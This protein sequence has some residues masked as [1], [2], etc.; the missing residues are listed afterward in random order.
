[1]IPILRVLL[2]VTLLGSC[3][4]ALG[5]ALGLVGGGGPNVAANVQ[6]GKTNTQNLSANQTNIA[7][8][9]ETSSVKTESV[10]RLVINEIPP[11]VILLLI[12]GW[13]LPTPGQIGNWF[14]SLFRR[15]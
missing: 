5:T 8:D 11:W 9:Q 4:G 7:G 13:L 1:V 15:K 12:V 2:L 14:Y 3:S 10:E 6:A